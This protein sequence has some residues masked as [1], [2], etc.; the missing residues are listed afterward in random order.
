[1]FWTFS[2]AIKSLSSWPTMYELQRVRKH[3]SKKRVY[4]TA[5]MRI[6]RV[7]YTYAKGRALVKSNTVTA[8]FHGAKRSRV[9]ERR[10]GIERGGGEGGR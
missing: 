6:L 9:G 4:Q 2:G 10:S 3:S 7:L 5:C 8:I 1:M